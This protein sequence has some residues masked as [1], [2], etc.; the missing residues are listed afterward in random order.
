MEVRLAP[1]NA[2]DGVDTRKKDLT[3]CLE[4]RSQD[5]D[6]QTAAITYLVPPGAEVEGSNM[7]SHWKNYLRTAEHYIKGD[8][9]EHFKFT[10][11]KHQQGFN[12]ADIKREC[13]KLGG[14]EEM[15]NLYRQF[16]NSYVTEYK[17]EP[18]P[19][20]LK[21]ALRFLADYNKELA[22]QNKAATVIQRAFLDFKYPIEDFGKCVKCE[23]S[24]MGDFTELCADCYWSE[25][26]NIKHERRHKHHTV[27]VNMV[28]MPDPEVDVMTLVNKS[29]DMTGQPEWETFWA[30]FQE[31]P[32]LSIRKPS[33]KFPC[34]RR[35]GSESTCRVEGRNMCEPCAEF[36]QNVKVCHDCGIPA[37]GPREKY[38][39]RCYEC[40]DAFLCHVADD[41]DRLRYSGLY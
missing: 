27:T 16:Y 35:C 39:H 25:D 1:A 31:R 13:L 11:F 21:S 2:R 40:Y 24:R 22:E 8:P 29:I 9:L 12:E 15:L 32:K 26:A 37:A 41:E 36:V 14:G 19:F 10:S 7:N 38:H 30:K 18:N 17:A 34:F 33:P 23:E 5:R 28:I 6:V 3:T 4:V 20:T